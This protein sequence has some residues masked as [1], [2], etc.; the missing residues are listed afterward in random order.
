VD[1]YQLIPVAAAAIG[2]TALCLWRRNLRTN[3]IAHVLIDAVAL[4]VVAL[5]LKDL[6]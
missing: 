1:A 3:I 2:L 6:Y 5:R 4:G